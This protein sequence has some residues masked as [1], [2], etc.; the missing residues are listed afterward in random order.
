M[1]RGGNGERG[2]KEGNEDPFI[3]SR[4]SSPGLLNISIEDVYVP[5]VP[6]VVGNHGLVQSWRKL[7]T[8]SGSGGEVKTPCFTTCST[9]EL[10][11]LLKSS[12]AT[13][14]TW[15]GEDGWSLKSC[16]TFNIFVSDILYNITISMVNWSTV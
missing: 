4:A 6:Y 10:A 12:V 7:A 9:A 3:T 11:F 2:M 14:M 15:G 13:S 1:G 5:P 8:S 16:Q